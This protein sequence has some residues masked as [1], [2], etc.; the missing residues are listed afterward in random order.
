MPSLI[1]SITGHIFVCPHSPIRIRRPD[2]PHDHVTQRTSSATTNIEQPNL[3][4]SINVLLHS[5]TCSP[6][7][8]QGRHYAS[9]LYLQ[10]VYQDLTIVFISAPAVA[11]NFSRVFHHPYFLDSFQASLFKIAEPSFWSR[12]HDIQD[13]KGAMLL[14]YQTNGPQKPKRHMQS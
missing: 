10:D 14:A 5:N 13:L 9:P 4:L 6:P 3:C 2:G 1:Y 8:K 7:Q 12:T 11:P